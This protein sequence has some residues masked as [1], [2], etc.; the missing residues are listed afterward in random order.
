MCT[1]QLARHEGY[2][3]EPCR[4]GPTELRILNLLAMTEVAP[5]RALTTP[6]S[7]PAATAAVKTGFRGKQLKHFVISATSP[8]L[9]GRLPKQIQDDSAI[10][11]T[12]LRRVFLER[13]QTY[14]RQCDR[15]YALATSDAAPEPIQQAKHGIWRGGFLQCTDYARDQLWGPFARGFGFMIQVK[16][17]LDYIGGQVQ[18]VVTRGSLA[19]FALDFRSPLLL[20]DRIK[21]E[22][23]WET[24]PCEFSHALGPPLLP[25]LGKG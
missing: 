25:L 19:W 11:T 17:A 10:S 6:E 3:I 22:I 1:V 5:L 2:P 4:P 7:S 13:S 9:P 14:L 24:G 15:P 8:G 21:V 18:Q 12:R 23:G 20:G 16:D